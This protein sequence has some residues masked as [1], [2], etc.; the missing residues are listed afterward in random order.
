M[1][2]VTSTLS[3]YFRVRVS[4]VL[5]RQVLPSTKL[6]TFPVDLFVGSHLW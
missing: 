1:L 5:T 3:C 2:K 4:A 6:S